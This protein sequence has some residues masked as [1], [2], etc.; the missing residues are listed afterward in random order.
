MEPIISVLNL[1]NG[2]GTSTLAWNIAH[3]LGLDLYQHDKAIH[4]LF[5][6]ERK[7]SIE[8]GTVQSKNVNVYTI[9][10]RQF[11]SGVYD[12]GSDINYGYVRQIL[13][14]SNVIVI[15]AELGAEVLIKTIATI[16]YVS[17]NNNKCDIFVVF[18]KLDNSDPARERKYTAEAV[19]RVE[20]LDETI[21]NRIKFY[22]IRYA[23]AMFRNLSEGYCLLDNFLR[24][25][26]P[27]FNIDNFRLLQHL[28]YYTLEKME[29]SASRKDK[30][31]REK[32]Q[33]LFFEKHTQFYKDFES[34]VDV[35]ALFD[36]TFIDNN[37]KIIKDMLILTTK[38]KGEYSLI[39]G[40]K[41]NV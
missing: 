33:S 37:T 35:S 24:P 19:M 20:E 11:K 21:V 31:E 30:A 5:Q 36:G 26:A 25:K 16:Q 22:Y 6:D 8:A 28:R 12:L 18:N 32:E 41:E 15:P 17:Q 10:K 39:W 34:H 13:S 40:G 38:I 1:K 29:K 2:V 14:K 27:K 9:E 7:Y 23:F 3:I 4:H